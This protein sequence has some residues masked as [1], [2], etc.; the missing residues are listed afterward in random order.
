M[1]W[2]PAVRVP[3][4]L[5]PHLEPV[6]ELDPAWRPLPAD[7]EVV[8]AYGRDGV[9]LFDGTVLRVVGHTLDDAGSLRLRVARSNYFALAVLARRLRDG[10]V[11]PPAGVEAA[12]ADPPEPMGVG[13]LVV[14]VLDDGDG[15]VVALTRRS[16]AVAADAGQWSVLPVCTMEANPGSRYGLGFHNLCREFGEEFFDVAEPAPGSPPADPDWFFRDPPAR[17]VLAECDAGR[18]EL[19]YLGVGVNP[20]DGAVNLAAIARFS[21]PS[22][23]SWVRGSVRGSWEGGDV[24]FVRLDDPF[25][26]ALADARELAPGSVFALDLARG[27]RA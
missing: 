23:G 10:A 21:S 7:A 26:D 2:S 19:A 6:L 13:L 1:L 16:A 18:A 4:E 15:A 9:R 3:G 11:R 5:G 27:R 12:L 24:R 8:A 22:F 14:T 17:R 20:M 25:L